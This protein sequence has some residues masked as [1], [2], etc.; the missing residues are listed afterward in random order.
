MGLSNL[1]IAVVS[2]YPVG[3][4]N[5]GDISLTKIHTDFPIIEKDGKSKIKELFFVLLINGMQNKEIECNDE[6]VFSINTN[7]EIKIR[8]T[9]VNTGRFMDLDS[10]ETKEKLGKKTE[11]IDGIDYFKFTHICFFENLDLPDDCEDNNFVIKVLIRKVI[12]DEEINKNTN[13]IIQ[14]IYPIQLTKI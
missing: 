1:N 5:T 7:Y 9:E 2:C 6:E 4:R 11:K 12:D 13:F 14:T 3:D 10:F 8:L